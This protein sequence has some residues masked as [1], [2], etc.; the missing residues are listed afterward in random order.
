VVF[1]RLSEAALP[2]DL[3]RR[4]ELYNVGKQPGLHPV[5][6]K[7]INALLVRLAKEGKRVVRLKGGDPYVFGRGGEE[8]Q[9]L[10][11]AKVPFEVVPGVTAAVAVPAYAGIPVT[12]RGEA[13]QVTLV[14][15]HESEKQTGPQVRWDLLAQN[16]HQ[17]LVGYMGVAALPEVVKKLLA[18]GMDPE[19]PAAMV[20]RGAT[21]GQRTVRS[22]LS[23]L[24]ADV[25]RA[26]LQP[27][28]IFIIGPS[29]RHAEE[30]DWF[31]KRPLFGERVLIAAPA[32]EFGEALD[33]NGAE[34]VEVPLPLTPAARVRMG[35]Y[36]LTGCLLRSP[37]EADAFFE[38]SHSPG[39][40]P[41][42]I[43][44]CLG[45]EA[46]HR[47]RNLGFWR[48]EEIESPAGAADVVDKLKQHL[49]ARSTYTK[50]SMRSR[51]GD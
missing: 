12:H 1:D 13:V 27:P 20:E 28:S 24:V 36:P 4:V 14:T 47:A 19:T 37:Y 5:P 40:S 6:Q 30:L 48:V 2:G 45:K 8:A 49:R 50:P 15:A 38:E 17:T 7:E 3:P 26:D 10:V 11:D 21:P 33:R 42:V 25:R 46:A 34:A 35:A 9:A 43:A 29:V 22:T 16:R 32:G 31:T 23:K 18:A 41:E 39:F 44:W 51:R